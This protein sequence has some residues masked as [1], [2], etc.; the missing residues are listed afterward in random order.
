MDMRSPILARRG[1]ADIAASSKTQNRC[2]EDVP[3]LVR[4]PIACRSGGKAIV[5]LQASIFI[6]TLAILVELRERNVARRIS[7]RSRNPTMKDGAPEGRPE[8]E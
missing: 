1:R 2:E 6:L 5:E 4:L 7:I 3:D 8:A